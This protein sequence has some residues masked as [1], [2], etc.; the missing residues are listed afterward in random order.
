M[1]PFILIMILG[2][3]GCCIF[4]NKMEKKI[5]ELRRYEFE[6]SSEGGT[7]SFSSFDASER[8]RNSMAKYNCLKYLGFCAL[9]LFLVF[10]TGG[11]L[12]VMAGVKM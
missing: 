7:I 2:A 12:L 11:I 5:K 4:M 8:H 9:M 3:I 6:N 10:F 1:G